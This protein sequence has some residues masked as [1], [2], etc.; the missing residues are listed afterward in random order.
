MKKR[1]KALFRLWRA[2]VCETIATANTISIYAYEMGCTKSCCMEQI[3]DVCVRLNK[4]QKCTHTKHI[5]HT[6]T[7]RQR[8]MRNG[9][10]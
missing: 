8:F 5:T 3:G 1:M 2:Y 6:H 10:R 7:L 4:S 9:L